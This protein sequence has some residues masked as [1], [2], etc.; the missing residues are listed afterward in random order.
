MVKIAFQNFFYLGAGKYSE[1][2]TNRLASPLIKT[3]PSWFKIWSG[4]YG[5]FGILFCAHVDQL[6]Q[7]VFWQIAGGAQFSGSDS[8]NSTSFNLTQLPFA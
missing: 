5:H 1:Q 7:D 6:E 4:G 8:Y 3:F 2:K